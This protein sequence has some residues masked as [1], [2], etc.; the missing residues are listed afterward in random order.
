MLNDLFDKL[1]KPDV[2]SCLADLSNDEVMTPPDIANKMLDLLPQE[3]F[4]NPD[5]KILDPFCKSGVFL[6]EAAKRFIEGEKDQFN[7][8]QECIDW[9]FQHQLYGIAITELTSL[10]SRRSVYCSKY[11][12][13]PYSITVFDKDNAQGNILYHRIQHEWEGKGENRRCKYCGAS[14]SE[15]DRDN[16]L[17]TYAYELIHTNKPEEILN[18]KF[19]VIIGNP[20]YQLNDGGG[21]GSA[22]TPI[23]QKFVE[24]AERLNPKYLTMIIPSRWFA[25]GRG[26]DSFRDSMLND[27]SIKV[28][29]DFV[30]AK[31]CFSGVDIPGGVMYFLREHDYSGDCMI[32]SHI[33]NEE[34][35]AYR[36]LNEFDINGKPVFIRYNEAVTIV[37]KILCKNETSFADI[38]SSSKPFGL[39]TTFRGET[40]ASKENPIKV[41][42]NGG[43]GYT[44][45]SF[46]DT[47][48][49]YINKY[50]IFVSASNGAA[51]KTVPYSVI[52]EPFVGDKGSVCTETF[53]QIGGFDSEE[54]AKNALTYLTTKFCRFLIALLKSTPRAT[55][56]VYSFVPMQ[57]FS[58]SWTD[59][60]LYKKY[61][62]TQEEIDFIEFLI[63][64]MDFSGGNDDA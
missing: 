1:Y 17:E 40:V 63:K 35:I 6:R 53:V 8:L 54:E 13:S 42:Q 11:P 48:I 34:T 2:L 31:D 56:I 64:P 26:L 32:V 46:I 49:D 25:G 51:S 5:T 37:N 47:E 62:L 22:A 43:C 41:Y 30:D 44:N 59:E 9:V 39:R 20:P 57:D 33:N 28:I 61:S 16:T 21:A 10:L 15:Y 29:H 23:Y 3:L 24:Q 38:V 18:M 55:K 19:D 4:S 52:S 12:N 58:K 60:E 36:Q 50:N 27:N 7:S 45:K 14:A